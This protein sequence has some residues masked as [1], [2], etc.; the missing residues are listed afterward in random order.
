MK[1]KKIRHMMKRKRKEK[2][3]ADLA[4]RFKS[5]FQSHNVSSL[6]LFYEYFQGEY[7]DKSK[8]LEENSTDEKCK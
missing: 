6:Y 7:S 4:S 5:L 8:K 1:V 3:G 2:T